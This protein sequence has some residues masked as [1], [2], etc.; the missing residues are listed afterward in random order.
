MPGADRVVRP[1]CRLCPRAVPGHRERDEFDSAGVDHAGKKAG[2]AFNSLVSGLN[3][4]AEVCGWQAIY[5]LDALFYEPAILSTMD[6]TTDGFGFMLVFG[7]LG[8]VPFTYSLQARYLVTHPRSLSS[9]EVGVII[10]IFLLGY[11]I[12]RGSNSQKDKYRQDPDA[13]Q[14]RNIKTMPTAR[15]RKLLIG[16]WWG[17][18]RH[19]NYLGDIIM[20]FSWCLPGAKR[21]PFA[22]WH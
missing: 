13:P 1:E 17:I 2:R 11:A 21:R 8:W 16:G 3:K 20:A 15:G 10:V 18:A 14:F 12:F 6:I 7:D 19:I 22:Y 5:V 4:A 9:I